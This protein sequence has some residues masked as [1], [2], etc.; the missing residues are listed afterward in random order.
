MVHS[1]QLFEVFLK[2][3]NK[4]KIPISQKVNTDMG[5]LECLPLLNKTSENLGDILKI[6]EAA[7]TKK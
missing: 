4:Q 7:T 2:Q 1:G 3:T 6:T 5:H